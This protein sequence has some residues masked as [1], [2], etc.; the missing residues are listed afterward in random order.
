MVSRGD[1]LQ[2]N[3]LTF[4]VDSSGVFSDSSVPL[5]TAYTGEDATYLV[6]VLSPQSAHKQRVECSGRGLCDEST[7]ECTCMEGF[8][9]A[10][11]ERVQCAEGCSENGV[12]LSLRRLAEATEDNGKRYAL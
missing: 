11:C 12:C 1:T 5:S 6:G 10:A 8:E 9:G 2:V 7:A 3:S 4:T